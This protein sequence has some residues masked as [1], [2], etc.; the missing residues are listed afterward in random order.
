MTIGPL[1]LFM[2]A[3]VAGQ[4]QA[5]GAPA[6]DLAEA[7]ALY[8]SAAYEDALAHLSTIKDDAV[9]EQVEQYRALCLLALGRTAEA[10]RAL[11]RIVMAKPLYQVSQADVSPRLVTMFRE[12][13]KRVLPGA[14]RDLYAK[15]KGSF[16][17]KEYSLASAQFKSLLALLTDADL[18]SQ[19]GDL[20]DLKMLG[21][22]FLKLAE[23]E[24]KP[25]APPP[26]P[27]PDPA[28]AVAKGPPPI[29]TIENRDVVPP[30]DVE[31][32]LPP[33][34]ATNRVVA[35]T[36]RR[37]ILE[38]VIDERGAVESAVLRAAVSPYYDTQLL[39]AARKWRF[40][41]AT[42]NGEPVKFRRLFAISLEGG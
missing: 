19:A 33:W 7:R 37:G 39:E 42:K 38:I 25:K 14:V 28:R 13:R 6:T 8:A 2:V 36:A 31:R 22:G 41:P 5:P 30:A 12:A 20:A 17:A 1:L 3:M 11:E 35:A 18:A 40:K 15:A 10:E 16:D 29:Y 24:L 9:A 32:R 34:D 4:A 21:E 23:E 26:P 27:A